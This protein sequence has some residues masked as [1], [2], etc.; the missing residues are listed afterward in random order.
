MAPHNVTYCFYII[1]VIRGK[2]T[3]IQKKIISGEVKILFHLEAVGS[4]S[5]AE[6]CR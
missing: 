4:L 6:T 3:Y 5:I 2:L 1:I